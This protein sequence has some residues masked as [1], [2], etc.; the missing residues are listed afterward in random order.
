MTIK[1]QAEKDNEDYEQGIMLTV[2]LLNIFDAKGLEQGPAISASLS[3]LI[4][5]VLKVMRNKKD[6][7]VILNAILEKVPEPRNTDLDE[8][9]N[10]EIWFDETSNELH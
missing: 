10:L 8:I 2:R 1:D 4:Q 3:V 9:D 6:A 7:Q 5:E